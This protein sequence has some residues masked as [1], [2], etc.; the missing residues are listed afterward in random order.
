MYIIRSPEEIERIQNT[1]QK[2]QRSSEGWQFAD[3]LL[4]S[5]NET[6][7]FFGALTFTIK[8]KLDWRVSSSLMQNLELIKNQGYLRQ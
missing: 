6:V 1:L 3:E 8:I 2:I 5:A 4:K 7:R